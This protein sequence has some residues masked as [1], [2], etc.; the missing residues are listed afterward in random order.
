M[1]A[2]IIQGVGR[3]GNPSANSGRIA[4]PSYYIVP[5]GG[6]YHIAYFK[7]TYDDAHQSCE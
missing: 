4:N 6:K 1:L 5:L 3:I 2:R 7:T